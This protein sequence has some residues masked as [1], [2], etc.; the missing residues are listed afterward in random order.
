[1]KKIRK[2]K[3]EFVDLIPEDVE[4]GIVYISLKYRSV[5]HKCCCGCGN[6]VNTPLS[7]VDWKLIFDGESISLY[8]SIGNW[9]FECQSH[10]WIRDNKVIWDYK[11]SK[12]KIEYERKLDRQLRDDYFKNN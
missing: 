10:Y 3:Y 2:I 9:N 11:W 4:E 6:E 1:M 5:I 8:P 12:E 7:P